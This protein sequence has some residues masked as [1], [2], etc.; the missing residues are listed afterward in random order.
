MSAVPIR[1][2]HAFLLLAPCSL[3]ALGAALD[4]LAAA[5]D[6]LGDD[7]HAAVT[8]SL[9]GRAV[10]SS[11]G[12]VIAV[13]H[14]LAAAPPA[15]VV[16][17]LADAPL[18]DHTACHAW[19]R[20]CAAAGAWLSGLGAGARV[21]ADAGLLDGHRATLDA[22]LSL[23]M[24]ERHPRVVVS[25]NLYEID[26]R[27]LTCAG[28]S[29]VLELMIAWLGQRHG[30]KLVQS[31][32]AHFGLERLRAADERPRAPSAARLGS[33]KLAEAVSLMEANLGEPLPTEDIARLV[34][35]SRR[36]LERLFKQHL[37]ELPSRYY[38]ELR[39][40]R[41]R[42]LLQQGNQSIL[43][44]GLACGFSSG[45]HFSNAY[46]ARFGQTPREARSQRA[47]AWREQTREVATS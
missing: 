14:S 10:R 3:H 23:A 45:S 12:V 30:D 24:A 20:A 22:T 32:L 27:R 2:Q 46:R 44:V 13:D 40:A 25:S 19:L 43:Q 35:V 29:A 38:A 18:A 34:G 17:V 7:V 37:D 26:R 15:N 9:D 33:S 1:A 47:M 36:Q 31:L 21:L 4:V 42:R 8:L 41:A 6:A 16:H 39:L 11:Q 5:N 28:G